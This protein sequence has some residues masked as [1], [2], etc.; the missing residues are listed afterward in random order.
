MQI[1]KEF[2]KKAQ[3]AIENI[4]V[5]SMSSTPTIIIFMD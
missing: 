4:I 5:A 2:K 3:T 1:F